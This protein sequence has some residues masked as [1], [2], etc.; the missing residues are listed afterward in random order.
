MSCNNRFEKYRDTFGPVEQVAV[1][2]LSDLTLMI[3]S[4]RNMPSAVEYKALAESRRLSQQKFYEEL[5]ALEEEYV[6][7]TS[8]T[9]VAD[10]VVKDASML[11]R[12]QFADGTESM[13]DE[14]ESDEL[15]SESGTVI[16]S[17]D[18]SQLSE[19]ES[20]RVKRDAAAIQRDDKRPMLTDKETRDISTSK[21]RGE[22]TVRD[23]DDR[24]EEEEE[25]DD[26]DSDIDSEDDED[27]DEIDEQHVEEEREKTKL[28]K[29]ERRDRKVKR[30]SGKEKHKGA[31]K[32][33]ETATGGMRR[34]FRKIKASI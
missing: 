21:R 27:V 29:K 2:D 16:R 22:G 25:E 23:K 12:S 20:T 1:G 5:E 8:S 28:R 34:R 9:V 26:D 18:R 32:A 24:V 31:V 15:L 33:P 11:E 10:G 30:D 4:A 6:V 17:D 3:M 14:A 19:I 7:E 13:V